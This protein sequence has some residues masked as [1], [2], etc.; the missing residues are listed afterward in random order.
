[1]K[2]LVLAISLVIA[3][4]VNVFSQKTD[5][6]KFGLNNEVINYI[7]KGD[8]QKVINITKSPNFETIT[9]RDTNWNG[10]FFNK[11]NPISDRDLIGYLSRIR[12]MINVSNIESAIQ[13]PNGVI[14][15][16]NNW[17]TNEEFFRGT[18]RENEMKTYATRTYILTKGNYT[19]YFILAFQ[20][21]KLNGFGIHFRMNKID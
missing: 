7:L 10:G 16:V 4:S 14:I 15:E 8:Y 20:N 11:Q 18:P 21:S 13:N 6:K 5:F 1:M 2:K 17:S 3:S 9:L 19:I 12:D